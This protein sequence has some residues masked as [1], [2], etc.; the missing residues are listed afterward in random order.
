[1]NVWFTMEKYSVRKRNELRTHTTTWVIIKCIML[2]E[3]PTCYMI[4]VIFYKRQN[5]SDR[6][7]IRGGQ[8]MELAA[9]VHENILRVKK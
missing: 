2:S 5:Y 6:K 7:Q 9:N 3:Q 8:W 1:M 4:Y